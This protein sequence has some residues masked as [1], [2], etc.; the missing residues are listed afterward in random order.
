MD[1][2]AR[3]PRGAPLRM[4]HPRAAG[5]VRDR[6]GARDQGPRR[7]GQDGHRQVQRRVQEDR[8]ALLGR[9][10]DDGGQAGQV[11]RL[12]GRLQD[13]VPVVHGD[14]VVGVQ[15]AVGQ[16]A[17]LP[18]IPRHA[19]LHRVRH[20]AVQL[21]GVAELQGRGGP[22]RDRGVPAGGRGR[23]QPGGVDHHAVD[24][25][26]QHGALRPPA[27]RIRQSQGS[28]DSAFSFTFD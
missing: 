4:G 17:R 28:P 10:G 11:D 25:A 21:W 16:G 19:L 20:A 6:Q 2:P 22:G 3:I 18:G 7:R 13:H 14:A 1:A 15:A 26:Q 5:G 12:Q 8:D 9:V 24:A 23:G 27:A